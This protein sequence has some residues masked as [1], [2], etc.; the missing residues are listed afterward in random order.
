MSD[1]GESGLMRS[2]EFEFTI[3]GFSDSDFAKEPTEQKSVS[4]W[5]VF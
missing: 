5:V 1:R 4:G 3:L 2:K